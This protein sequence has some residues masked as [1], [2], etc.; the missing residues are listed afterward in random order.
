MIRKESWTPNDLMISTLHEA[1]LTQ[2]THL[3]L[4]TRKT[5][6][7][8]IYLLQYSCCPLKPTCTPGL[9]IISYIQSHISKP[10]V[11]SK[12]STSNIYGLNIMQYLHIISQYH[13]LI[14]P[15]LHGSLNQSLKIINSLSV[16]MSKV[17]F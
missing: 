2:S 16:N 12:Q 11:F 5:N 8:S 1:S 10:R 17:Q 14:T 15:N 3:S 6:S 9:Y 13:S 7:P 4:S